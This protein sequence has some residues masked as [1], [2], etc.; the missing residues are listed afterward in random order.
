MRKLVLRALM[1][2]ALLGVAV[3]RVEAMDRSRTLPLHGTLHATYNP[4]KCP[5]GTPAMTDGSVTPCYLVI[6]HGTIS[7]LGRVVDRRVA[8]LLH[9]TTKCPQV[10]FRIA[11]TFGTRGTIVAAASKLCVDPQADVKTL[12]FTITGGTGAFARATGGGTITVRSTAAGYGFE[13]ETWKGRL[14][15]PR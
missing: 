12:P 7:N 4:A 9:S 11:L 3:G 2:M 6:A 10:D 1:L 5:A 14:T 15:L 13:N 8:I